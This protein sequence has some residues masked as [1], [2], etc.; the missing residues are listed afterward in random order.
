MHHG[1]ATR[2]FKLLWHSTI[3]KYAFPVQFEFLRQRLPKKSTLTYE[4][5]SLVTPERD[6]DGGA[7]TFFDA[8]EAY[9]ACVRHDADCEHRIAEPAFAQW[10]LAVASRRWLWKNSETPRRRGM[11]R[12]RRVDAATALGH[13]ARR[14]CGSRARR[15]AMARVHV[16][17]ARR[18]GRHARALRHGPGAARRDDLALLTRADCA[19]ALL[20]SSRT[21][22]Y[23]PTRREAICDGSTPT[24]GVSPT[25]ARASGRPSRAS[26][27]GEW[28]NANK[29]PSAADAD[30]VRACL[31]KASA[32]TKHITRA[33]TV[34]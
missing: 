9:D 12:R 7:R 33:T 5:E 17:R 1:Y 13:S 21:A 14:P 22:R 30:A 11:R 18:V 10:L 4:M 28:H 19:S 23:L 6:V 20:L 31:E 29:S 24:S 3:L 2:T 26:R 34:T 8:L 32:V 27:R 25:A 16:R 15:S